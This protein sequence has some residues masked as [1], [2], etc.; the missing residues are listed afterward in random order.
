[1]NPSFFVNFESRNGEQV[2]HKFRLMGYFFT[3]FRQF[4]MNY[5]GEFRL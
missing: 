5:M 4:F 2:A 1:M 3:F